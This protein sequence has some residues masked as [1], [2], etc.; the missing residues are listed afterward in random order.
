MPL[1]LH[2]IAIPVPLFSYFQP[3]LSLEGASVAPGTGLSCSL[4][5]CPLSWYLFCL[6]S[7]FPWLQ[8]LLGRQWLVLPL[9]CPFLG[10]WLWL[11]KDFN[12]S[13]VSVPSCMGQG[14][15]VALVPPSLGYMG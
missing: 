9:F 14:S 11:S 1:C 2:W 5:L 10:T 3:L 15:A 13:V 4:V 8:I 12:E 6:A 7:T